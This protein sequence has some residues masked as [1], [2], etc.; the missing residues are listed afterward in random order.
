MN[1][2]TPPERLEATPEIMAAPQGASYVQAGGMRETLRARRL[3]SIHTPWDFRESARKRLPRM[4]FDYIDGGAG[5]EASVREAREAI[6]RVRLLP[7][8]PHDT[9]H[10]DLSTTLFG[11]HLSMPIV[12]G[13]T[14][15]ASASEPR[16]EV[17]FSRAAHRAGIRFVLSN[18]GSRPPEDVAAAGPGTTWFQ[19]YTPPDREMARQWIGRVKR[20]GFTALE[21]TVDVAATGRRLRDARNGFTMPFRWTPGKFLDC[22]RHPA[23][24]MKMLKYGQPT[25]F[26]EVERKGDGPAPR[27]QSENL[28]H[29]FTK[30][31]SWDLLKMVRDEWDGPLIV[32]GLMDPRQAENAVRAGF[33]GI[34]LSN[35]G[36]RQ[37]AS[38][39]SPM[40]VLP[41]FVSEVGGRIRI[42]ID[43]GFRS[44]SDIVKAIAMGADAVQLGRLTV[45]ALATAGEMGVDHCLKLLRDEME[46]TMALCGATSIGQLD[47][48]LVRI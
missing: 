28:K 32:K 26:F 47:R 31:L 37:L 29:R 34:V 7:S 12:I 9:S 48:N 39:V 3:A 46:N 44:G 21:V 17:L 19:L 16:G 23:W 13:P 38:A 24:A 14:G 18:S 30:S 6:E 36:G 27:N 10:I 11:Q 40:E 22:A 1:V 15:L 25:P 5:D 33:D 41:E 20:C 4:V 35:H 45:F 2:A 43:G 8:A 42:L